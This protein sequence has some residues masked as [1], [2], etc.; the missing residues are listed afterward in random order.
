MI[1]IYAFIMSKYN[2]TS[3]TASK[4]QKLPKLSKHIKYKFDLP[5]YFSI[6]RKARYEVY[7]F[8]NAFSKYKLWFNFKNKNIFQLQHQK[9]NV[10]TY[11]LFIYSQG[12][13]NFFQGRTSFKKFFVITEFIQFL[14]MRLVLVGLQNAN[15]ISIYDPS[16]ILPPFGLLPPSALLLSSLLMKHSY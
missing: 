11:Y 16:A 6:Q 9:N 8:L 13:M 10:P 7:N 2:D 12:R 4:L 5:R 3:L 1:Y 14:T 15:S